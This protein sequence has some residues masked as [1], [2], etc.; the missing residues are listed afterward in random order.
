MKKLIAAV[1]VSVFALTSCGAGGGVVN[2]S[3]AEF[4]KTISEK[5]VVIL[6]VRTPGEF[7][8]GHIAGAINID[9][10]G[11]QFDTEIGKLDKRLTYAVYC[12][13]GRR[14]GIATEKMSLASFTHL[15]NL[16]G[17]AQDW[18]A[19]GHQLVTA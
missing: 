8:E 14:S 10:E 1:I 15:F 6:D 18:I 9:V 7:M 11:M 19:T 3:S 16:T 5:S 12:H 4:E 17:G 2:Q 13:S